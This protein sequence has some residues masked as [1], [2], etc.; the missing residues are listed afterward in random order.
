[1]GGCSPAAPADL[2][3]RSGGIAE[4]EAGDVG[5][6]ACPLPV[7]PGRTPFPQAEHHLERWITNPPLDTTTGS[8]GPA[9]SAQPRRASTTASAAPI[10]T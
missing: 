6:A 1:M 3:F 8:P 9:S 2:P 5:L 7:L 4:I 10:T